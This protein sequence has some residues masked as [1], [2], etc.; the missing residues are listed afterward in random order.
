MKEEKDVKD[1]VKQKIR[2]KEEEELRLSQVNTRG[3]DRSWPNDAR[4]VH[5]DRTPCSEECMKTHSDDGEPVLNKEGTKTYG[6]S[7]SN[8]LP[9]VPVENTNR[10]TEE[11]ITESSS[12]SVN[13]NQSEDLQNSANITT[14]LPAVPDT[15]T[16][17]V[18]SDDGKV[19]ETPQSGMDTDI[20]DTL[21]S[22]DPLLPEIEQNVPDKSTTENIDLQSDLNAETVTQVDTEILDELNDF[23]NY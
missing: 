4:L 9:G 8:E 6:S 13:Q 18:S 19:V 7:K 16:K 11:T 14:T 17:T 3:K 5:P 15:A 1:D 10:F 23:S 20:N 21:G 2:I 12:Q 22:E